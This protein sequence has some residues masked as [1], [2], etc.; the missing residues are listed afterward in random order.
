MGDSGSTFLGIFYSGLSLQTGN[1]ILSISLLLL[2]GPIYIDTIITIIKRL[3]FKQNILKGHKLHLYQRLYQIG[4]KQ[5]KIVYVYFI[6]SLF[7]AISFLLFKNFGLA[8]G[9]FY[10]DSKIKIKVQEY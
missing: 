8:L 5:S 9:Y 1:L 3:I 7:I 2:L 4:I 10:I 6:D